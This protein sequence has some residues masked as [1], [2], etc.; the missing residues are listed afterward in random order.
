[1]TEST[2]R[3]SVALVGAGAMGRA[4]L[5]GWLDKGAIDPKRSVVFEPNAGQ[6]LKALAHEA[7]LVMN[8]HAD[9][10]RAEALVLAVKP[11]AAAEILPSF[12][13]TANRALTISIL[14]G[15]SLRTIE[16]HLKS[17]RICR[18]MPNLA[19]QI[20]S[21]VCGLFAPPTVCAADRAMADK[22]MAAAGETVWVES[23]R[24]I[25]L[26]TALSGSGPA[27]FF[28]M[29]EALAEAGA[30]LGL[31][32]D[33]ATRLARATAIG[34]GA[35]LGRE[36]TDAV[37]LRKRVTSPGGTTAAALAVLDGE[38]KT[39]RRL[40]IEALAAAAKRAGEMSS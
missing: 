22:L 5:K 19:S 37:D 18:A 40:M 10:C 30:S 23:E 31:Q 12:A 4:L 8:A 24:E 16:N 7:G 13:A 38:E 26:V 3:I 21:G 25:D 39:L 29:V 33:A 6:D 2:D 34:A 17:A 9:D 32:P 20:G 36:T 27:Y 14:A 1:M 11:Q 28:L 15:T 35:L